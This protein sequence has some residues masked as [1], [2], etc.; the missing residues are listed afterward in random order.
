MRKTRR[1]YPIEMKIKRLQVQY[2]NLCLWWFQW[3]K[4]PDRARNENRFAINNTILRRFLANWLVERKGLQLSRHD[5]I[6]N[7]VDQLNR[8][9]NK[10]LPKQK[11]AGTKLIFTDC[12]S[13][14]GARIEVGHKVDM[15]GLRDT[16]AS[17]ILFTPLSV[18]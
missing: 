12:F 2:A 13:P 6:A 5:S 11:I 7:N 16:Q 9:E 15:S 1:I 8:C 17:D 10:K 4:A 18:F 14:V 3:Y